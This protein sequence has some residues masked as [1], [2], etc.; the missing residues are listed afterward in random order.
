MLGIIVKKLLIAI[1][2]LSALSACSERKG[3]ETGKKLFAHYCIDCHYVSKKTH[4][5]S[6]IKS[7]AL[8]RRSSLTVSATILDDQ[9][10]GNKP[11]KKLNELSQK[12]SQKIVKYLY[13]LKI[14]YENFGKI[15]SL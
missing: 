1:C 12:E 3:L 9:K 2:V 15:E 4:F 11:V 6:D 5:F 14:E 10:H 13:Q 7:S 8:S